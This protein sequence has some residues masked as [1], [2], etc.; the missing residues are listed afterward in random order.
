VLNL[1]YEQIDDISH[2]VQKLRERWDNRLDFPISELGERYLRGDVRLLLHCS[3][4]GGELMGRKDF[5]LT[6]LEKSQDTLWLSVG[7][8]IHY[9]TA[10]DDG[11]FSMLIESVHIVDDAKGIVNGII[12]SVVRLNPFDDVTDADFRN[13][14]YLSLITS[15]FI[16]CRRSISQDRKSD[17]VFVVQ[18]IRVTGEV[19]CDVIHAR[20]QMVNGFAAQNAETDWDR[21]TPVVIQSFLKVLRI[22][23]GNNWVLAYAEETGDL[24]IKIDDVLIGP[25]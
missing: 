15:Q 12:P 13:S 21:Q 9:G 7:R 17:G 14:L 4:S 6:E 19:P 10:S 18:P 11:Q 8:K 2:C 20:S 24:S 22:W 5:P 16:F 25:F 1:A 23:I 3:C